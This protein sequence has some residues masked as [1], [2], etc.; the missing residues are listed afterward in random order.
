[1]FQLWLKKDSKH[2]NI[3]S[4]VNTFIKMQNPNTSTGFVVTAIVSQCLQLLALVFF[5]FCCV[6]SSPDYLSHS[7]CVHVSVH[8][9]QICFRLLI[10][11]LWLAI[12][13]GMKR[14]GQADRC[15]QCPAELLPQLRSEPLN[16][17]PCWNPM[18]TKHMLYQHFWLSL[19]EGSLGKATKWVTLENW[20]TKVKITM[21]PW[22]GGK[23]VIK[24]S[25]MCDQGWPGMD[26]SLRRPKGV[27]LSPEPRQ[28]RWRHIRCQP[29]S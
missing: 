7:M 28:N 27:M 24:S 3:V 2:Y 10:G 4:S 5:P 21:L 26:S 15:P 8:T 14:R 29:P 6:P 9:P 11:P 17:E 19:A 12:G 16:P 13:M 20:S 1:M 23:P 18:Q 25:A 22:E